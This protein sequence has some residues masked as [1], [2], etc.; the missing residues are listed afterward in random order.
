MSNPI[1]TDH[2]II[3]AWTIS[4]AESSSTSLTYDGSY[5]RGGTW[6]YHNQDGRVDNSTTSFIYTNVRANKSDGIIFEGTS[7]FNING[8]SS[9]SEPYTYEGDII[10]LADNTCIATF[11]TGEQYEIDLNTG[12]VTPL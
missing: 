7:T 6:V 8:S 2:T 11:S 12:E 10:F 1:D 9:I 4:G 5:S 3:G